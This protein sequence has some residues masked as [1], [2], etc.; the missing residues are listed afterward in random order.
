MNNCNINEDRRSAVSRS[1]DTA[2]LASAVC[3]R[4]SHVCGTPKM[5]EGH[6]TSTPQSY[7]ALYSSVRSSSS[8]TQLQH[9][10]IWDSPM[11]QLYPSLL[12]SCKAAQYPPDNCE[13][14]ER[15]LFGRKR[16]PVNASSSLAW[17]SARALET[18]SISFI[19]GAF[20]FEEEIDNILTYTM[21]ND[22]G[23]CL[24]LIETLLRPVSQLLILF[25]SF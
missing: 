22:G 24:H 6:T 23:D 12:H 19:T 18:T 7:I 21:G 14:Q 11:S 4:K 15:W 25:H 2:G 16:T 13:P 20:A 3:P 17:G 10:V 8:L 9:L 5:E 1:A